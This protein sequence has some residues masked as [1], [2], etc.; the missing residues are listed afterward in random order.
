[1]WK[2]IEEINWALLSKKKR[3]YEEGKRYMLENFTAKRGNEISE[4][5]AKRF[6]ELYKRIEKYEQA[7]DTHCGD[8]GGDDSFGDMIHHV[9]GLGEAKFNEIMEDPS[10]LNG[11]DFVESFGYC[12]PY[13][14]DYKMLSEDYHVERAK[15]AVVEL[16]RIATENAPSGQDVMV[17]KELM[18]R[19]LL[20]IAGDVHAAMEDYDHENDYSRLYQFEANDCMAQFANYISDC[21]KYKDI[22]S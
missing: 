5:I 1:M 3:G 8:Y 15:Q 9:I 2:Y 6:K 4:F 19:F 22:L 14:E 10:K 20:I 17:I 21:H 7:N 13:E 16:A 11:M 12:M 18:D